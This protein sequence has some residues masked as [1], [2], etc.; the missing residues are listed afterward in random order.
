[1]KQVHGRCPKCGRSVAVL[2]LSPYTNCQ[3]CGQPLKPP[4]NLTGFAVSDPSLPLP[5]PI[6]LHQ[7]RAAGLVGAVLFGGFLF[8]GFAVILPIMALLTGPASRLQLMLGAVIGLFGAY[9]CW[10]ALRKL[11]RIMSGK[12]H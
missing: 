7:L 2:A 11:W 6:H 8:F 12:G 5:E 4:S 1:M 10:Q 9:I 3:Y